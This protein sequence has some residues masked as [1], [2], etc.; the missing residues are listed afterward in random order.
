MKGPA[1]RAFFLGH[2]KDT[3][4]PISYTNYTFKCTMSLYKLAEKCTK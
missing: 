1:S 4:G 3:I 2:Y